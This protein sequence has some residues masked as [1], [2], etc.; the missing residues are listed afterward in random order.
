[1]KL[2]LKVILMY[3]LLVFAIALPVFGFFIGILGAC[4]FC[5]LCGLTGE[6]K[7]WEMAIVGMAF[8]YGG[9]SGGGGTF[10]IITLPVVMFISKKLE[11][12]LSSRRDKLL[13]GLLEIYSRKIHE[14][15][16]S[17]LE[18]IRKIQEK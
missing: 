16:S 17:E 9:F 10:F 14:F 2:L 7:L 4:G 13:L 18:S 15:A 5:N 11:I 8:F 1:M 6:L 12:N 3:S